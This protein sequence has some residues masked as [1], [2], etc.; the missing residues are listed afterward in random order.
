MA[1]TTQDV[2][3]N[4]NDDVTKWLRGDPETGGWFSYNTGTGAYDVPLGVNEHLHPTLGDINF[5]GTVSA[6]G[7]AGMTGEFEGTFKKIKIQD[8]IITEFELV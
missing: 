1:D 2:W 4:T 8:G 3:V 7:F 6:D 5:T